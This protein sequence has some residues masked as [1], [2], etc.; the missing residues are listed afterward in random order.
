MCK[1]KRRGM[2]YLAGRDDVLHGSRSL[3]VCLARG[4]E[5]PLPFVD[6]NKHLS[7]LYFYA[8]YMISK[9]KKL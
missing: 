6:N 2:I 8:L 4:L 9:L 3:E 5:Y 1:Q 7:K